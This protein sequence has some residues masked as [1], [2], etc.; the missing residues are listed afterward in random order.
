MMWQ[1]QAAAY[2]VAVV[3][4]AH[5][6]AAKLPVRRRGCRGNRAFARREMKSGARAI[7]VSI[8]RAAN[9]LRRAAAARLAP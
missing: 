6:E 2:H 1:Q 3:G 9:L 5:R 4:T 7:I 8:A